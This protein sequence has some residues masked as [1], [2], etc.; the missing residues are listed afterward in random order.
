MI[1]VSFG[2]TTNTILIMYYVYYTS[3]TMDG[4]H[5]KRI[6]LTID[7]ELKDLIDRKRG[8]EPRAPFL[9]RELR[10]HFGMAEA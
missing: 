5:K 10:K 9:N 3:D 4:E 2:N 8:R 7:P 1:R 6:S